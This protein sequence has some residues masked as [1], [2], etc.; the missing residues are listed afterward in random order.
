MENWKIIKYIYKKIIELVQLLD[1]PFTGSSQLKLE[2]VT[3]GAIE[4]DSTT[5]RLM[6]GE[7]MHF[8]M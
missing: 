6:S 4:L 7:H 5:Q 1:G 2:Q 3:T 8:Y